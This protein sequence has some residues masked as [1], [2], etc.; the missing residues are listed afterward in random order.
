VD[1]KKPLSRKE[2]RSSLV[3]V[4]AAGRFPEGG[5]KDTTSVGEALYRPSGYHS[6]VSR[7]EKKEGDN[8]ASLGTQ[9]RA[10]VLRGTGGVGI[11][12]EE[13][14]GGIRRQGREE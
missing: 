8:L 4:S 3:G 10:Q 12:E 13:R 1:L 11:R 6:R 14:E 2:Y 7:G 9:G 5:T